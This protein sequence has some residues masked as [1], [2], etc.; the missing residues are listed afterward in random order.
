MEIEKPVYLTKRLLVKLST[1]AFRKAAT[2][3]M[4]VMGYVVI[5]EDGWIIKKFKDGTIEK[6][7]ELER[8]NIPLIF[9]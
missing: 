6:I 4:E 8:S 2:E 1:K 3:A 9:D 7:H 5:E